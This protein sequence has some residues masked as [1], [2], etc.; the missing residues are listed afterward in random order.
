MH[1]AVWSWVTMDTVCDG[2][3]LWGSTFCMEEVT[4]R[5]WSGVL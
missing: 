4:F 1:T 2:R 3:G 5:G